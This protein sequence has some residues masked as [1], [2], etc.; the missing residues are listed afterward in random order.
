MKGWAGSGQRA[1]SAQSAGPSQLDSQPLP[2]SGVQPN[3]P[4][5]FRLPR[6]H[7]PAS[8]CPSLAPLG[9]S[10]GNTP[11]SSQDPLPEVEVRLHWRPEPGRS[12]A[13]RAGT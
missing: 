4:S 11:W 13:R 8:A 1:G 3:P 10:D 7:P 12:A 9:L 6:D 2:L 5:L